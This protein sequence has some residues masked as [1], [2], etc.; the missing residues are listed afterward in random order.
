MFTN[1]I[2]DAQKYLE[3]LAAKKK[4]KNFVVKEG[5]AHTNLSYMFT[6]SYTWTLNSWDKN[7][8]TE[9]IVIYR[10]AAGDFLCS[11]E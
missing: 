1:C 9:V 6:V 5:R 7:T 2:K 11:L 10:P 3:E 8:E 4:L